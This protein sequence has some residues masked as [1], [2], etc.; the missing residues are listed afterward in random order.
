MEYVHGRDARASNILLLTPTAVTD[1]EILGA[2]A[3][4]LVL[5]CG[6]S[7]RRSSLSPRFIMI[8]MVRKRVFGVNRMLALAQFRRAV[9]F[10]PVTSESYM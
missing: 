8:A 4:S 1:D 7:L 2:R 3:S 9:P 5:G 10:L 6:E